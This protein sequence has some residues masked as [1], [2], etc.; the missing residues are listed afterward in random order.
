MSA[1]LGAN[2]A[3]CIQVHETLIILILKLGKELDNA[4]GFSCLSLPESVLLLNCA[5]PLCNAGMA[6]N[7]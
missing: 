6:S 4:D 5:I 3:E 7:S 1:V 2:P